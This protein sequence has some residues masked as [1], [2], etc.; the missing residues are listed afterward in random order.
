MM[1]AGMMK[2]AM[3]I[4]LPPY[5]SSLS[6]GTL[7]FNFFWGLQPLFQIRFGFIDSI[8]LISANWEAVTP[9]F[10]EP[11]VDAFA[12]LNPGYSAF[13]LSQRSLQPGCNSYTGER[14]NALCGAFAR[15]KPY[16]Y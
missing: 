8:L 9:L 12:P 7:R 14:F 5:I 16:M 1:A 15:S 3:A 11:Y 13:I 4:A 10:Q 6:L 2:L